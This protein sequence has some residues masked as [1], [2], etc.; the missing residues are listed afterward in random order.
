MSGHLR[1]LINN[2][3]ANFYFC[4]H[5]FKKHTV[6]ILAAL[7]CNA[8]NIMNPFCSKSV[9][10]SAIQWKGRSWPPSGFWNRIAHSQQIW[11][12]GVIR[13]VHIYKEYHSVCPL[14]EFGLPQPPLPQASVPFPRTKVGG[15]HS[16]AVEGWGSPNSDDWRKGLALIHF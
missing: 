13:K 2:R 14:A 11:I 6:F 15:A 4:Q 16:T 7:I 3:S 1:I 5:P 12:V 9:Q 8:R 10:P